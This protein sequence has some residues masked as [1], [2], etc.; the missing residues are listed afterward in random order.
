MSLRRIASCD[1]L[2]NPRSLIRSAISLPSFDPLVQ[3]HTEFTV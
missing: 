1:V 2:G 3:G